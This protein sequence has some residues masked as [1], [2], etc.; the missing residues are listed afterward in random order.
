MQSGCTSTQVGQMEHISEATFRYGGSSD[1]LRT[2]S[3]I[4]ELFFQMNW[5]F[6]RKRRMQWGIH[7]DT[8]AVHTAISRH[9]ALEASRSS[10]IASKDVSR[11][12]VL[13]L[14]HIRDTTIWPKLPC[15][16]FFGV[17]V[18]AKS[19]FPKITCVNCSTSLTSF[20]ATC[21]DRLASSAGC[22]E[23]AVWT[24]LVAKWITRCIRLLR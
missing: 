9:P 12:L 8:R 19:W 4:I 17:G 24:A 16:K 6:Y 21:D 11:W 18:Y 20:E 10:Q 13:Q 22:L 5:R 23:E 3:C 7:L 2:S 15:R 1:L 14:T